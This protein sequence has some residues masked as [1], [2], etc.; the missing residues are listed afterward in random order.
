MRGIRPEVFK[1]DGI[2]SVST[3]E[4]KKLADIEDKEKNM[5]V[6]ITLGHR[7]S[8]H[9]RHP[10]TNVLSIDAPTKRFDEIIEDAM[11]LTG[12]PE[13]FPELVIHD[14]GWRFK[15][16]RL[17]EDEIQ[18]VDSLYQYVR[19]RG[20]H[21]KPMDQL[22]GIRFFKPART[23]ELYIEANPEIKDA[24]KRIMERLGVEGNPF[25]LR[26]W[27][28]ILETKWI[29]GDTKGFFEFSEHLLSLQEEL[30]RNK[31][32]QDIAVYHQIANQFLED[33]RIQVG[34]HIYEL[35]RIAEADLY[36]P[37]IP[38]WHEEIP[39]GMIIQ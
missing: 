25:D 22:L 2:V 24:V 8:V 15:I 18:G 3:E 5:S 17:L 33:H 19:H 29:T 28:S 14:F 35:Q 38:L 37:L 13:L 11:D 4:A 36:S 31:F 10:L 1:F 21:T 30:I 27:R 7:P 6:K 34:G 39:K 23:M 12:S 26:R 32:D 9:V 20:Y 16:P